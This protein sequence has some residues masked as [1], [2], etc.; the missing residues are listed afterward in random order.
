MIRERPFEQ[1]EPAEPD[2]MVA[3]NGRNGAFVPQLL[4]QRSACHYAFSRNLLGSNV[5]LGDVGRA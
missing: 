3:P 1:F 5:R 4:I 2:T